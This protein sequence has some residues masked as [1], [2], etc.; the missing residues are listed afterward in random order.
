[1]MKYDT[2]KDS[3]IEW[4]GD[5]PENWKTK[6]LKDLLIFQG[7]YAFSSKDFT[8]DDEGVQVILIGNLYKN[9]LSLERN[10]SFVS[11]SYLKS[12]K[13]FIVSNRD[14]LISLTGTLGKKDYGF[15]I[16]LK[17]D[18]QYLLNQR[19]GCLRSKD[20]ELDI[21]WLIYLLQSD[22][23]Y[24]ELLTLPKGTKQG[25]LSEDQIFSIEILFPSHTEQKAIA[26]YLD[27]RTQAI[28]KKVRLLQQKIDYYT[29][30]RVSIINDAV[31]KGLDKN[32]E[33]KDSGIDWIG[34]IPKH[35]KVKRIKD[36]FNTLAG[37]TPSTKNPD[38]WDGEIPWIPSGNIQNNLVKV[39]SVKDYITEL[40]LKESSTKI[41]K[42]DLVLIALTG[43][44]CSNIGY[45]T[46]DTTI[47]QSIVAISPKNKSVPKFYYYFL[48]SA[49]EK[50]RT[51][52]S[53]GAQ[54]GINQEDVRFFKILVPAKKEQTEIAQYLDDKTSTIDAIVANI[55]KQIDHLQELRKTVINDVVTG[56]IRVF[57]P[58]ENKVVE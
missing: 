11:H 46:F 36:D 35:W 4:L 20:A 43:A 1:M 16:M 31:T 51:L 23:F 29:E 6:R 28:D 32:V 52:M 15:S 3:G 47:N 25:N 21:N 34:Q 33:L 7:G 30:L 53:G 57:K 54:G 5:I 26:K 44:T 27:T 2:Y 56:K 58:V 18:N 55:G 42:R 40:G 8:L 50:I 17:S 45:L 9:K 48:I 22:L 13:K 41:A 12:H 10:P 49:K 14:I 37:G 38:Y 39:D 24:S 19:V